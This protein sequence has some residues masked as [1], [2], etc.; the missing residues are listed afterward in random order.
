MIQILSDVTEALKTYK[1]TMTEKYSNEWALGFQD[2]IDEV[3]KLHKIYY[4]ELQNRFLEDA[5]KR[6]KKMIR[7]GEVNEQEQ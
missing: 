3:E 5:N 2:A 6:A 1:E 7:T 4:D